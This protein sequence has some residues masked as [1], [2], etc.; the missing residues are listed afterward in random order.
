MIRLPSDIK[1]FTHALHIAD[2]HCRAKGERCDEYTKVF[3]QLYA[4][5]DTP[6]A[7]PS[8]T[9]IVVAGDVFHD[10]TDLSPES[11]QMVSNFLRSLAD[12]RQTILV[13]GN[14]DATLTNKN[15][16]DSLTP[17]VEALNHENLHYLTTSDIYI[18]GDVLINNYSVFDTYDKYIKYEDIPSIYRNE[19]NHDIVLFHGVVDNAS[20]DNNVKLLTNAGITVDTFSGHQMAM[21]GD[22]HKHQVLQEYDKY[23]GKPAIVYPSSLIQQDHGESLHGHGFVYWN[24]KDKSFHHQH[25]KNEYGFFTIEVDDGVLKTDITNIPKKTK[26]RVRYTAGKQSEFDKILA[27]ITAITEIVDVVYLREEIADENSDDVKVTD[28]NLQDVSNVNYQNDLIMEYVKNKE[29]D[30]DQDLL[31]K[32]INVNVELN[33][34]LKKEYPVRNV[35]WKPKTLE[36]DNMFSY[37]EGNVID[38]TKMR[39]TVGLFAANAHGKTSILSALCFC[40]FDKCDR[41]SKASHILNTRKSKFRCKLTF[42][43]NGVDHYIERIGVLDKKN[44]TV[45]V[46]VE[47]WKIVDGEKIELN[48]S[49]R[50]GTN[51][52]IRDCVGSYDDFIL[53]T[54]SVQNGKDSGFIDLGQTQQKEFLAQFMGLT[55]YDELSALASKKANDISVILKNL[56]SENCVVKLGV[57]TT[58]IKTNGELLASKTEELNTVIKERDEKNAE[59]LSLAV[60]KIPM[61]VSAADIMSLEKKKI[62]TEQRL[63]TARDALTKHTEKANEYDKELKDLN[64]RLGVL[65]KKNLSDTLN[66]YNKIKTDHD[67]VDRQITGLNA[68]INSQ[69][70]LLNT[71]AKHEYDP[72][73]KYCSNSVFIIAAKKTKEELKI[74]EHNALKLTEERDS[75]KEKLTSLEWVMSDITEYNGL[76]SKKSDLS[77]K[78]LKVIATK[79]KTEND[80]TSYETDLSEISDAIEACRKRKDDILHNLKLTEEMDALNVKI[81]DLNDKYNKINAAYITINGQLQANSNEKLRLEEKIAEI[82]DYETKHICYKTY[83]QIVNRD[84]IPYELITRTVPLVENEVNNVLSQLADFR[85]SI[86]TDGKNVNTYIVYSEDRR[87]ALSTGSGFER[88][89]SSVA[90]RVALINISN[91]PRPAFLAIDEGFGSADKDNVIAM[92]K[93]FAYLKKQFDFV[94]IISHVDE[95]KPMMDI[96]LKIEKENGFS[97]IEFI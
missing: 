58:N 83:T 49:E 55:V 18:I 36:I 25:I 41:A 4:A 10:K 53:T 31:E 56:N 32:I 84:G 47:F 63:S 23:D 33:D 9:L 64:K 92:S 94:W 62:S 43:L 14:H 12:R 66:K 39:G 44:G 6:D 57:V 16:L 69:R 90:I 42:D 97:K 52:L 40:L 80:V 68:N 87:W 5:L 79:T 8:T 45:K 28:V 38:F 50:R 71:H 48:G 17:I 60:K 75:L 72:N 34:E 65:S 46:G 54:L 89:I 15:R 96:H 81:K 11:V 3:N 86:K 19:V 59:M 95:M 35:R 22:I 13:P 76:M 77:D 78:N 82:K 20:I 51:D 24:L 93:L 26:L 29:L 74:N 30:I 85:L 27:D 37:G 88:F 2:I 61:S 7:I 21:L 70:E 67:L 1:K 91:L 73:C